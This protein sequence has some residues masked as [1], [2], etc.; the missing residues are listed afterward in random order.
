[1]NDLLT[2]QMNNEFFAAYTYI[3]GAGSSAGCCARQGTAANSHPAHKAH[4]QVFMGC[5]S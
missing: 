3:R 2:Q 1:M 4:N 5:Y